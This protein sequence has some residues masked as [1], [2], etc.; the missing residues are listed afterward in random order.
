MTTINEEKT[1]EC[2]VVMYIPFEIW[3]DLYT[4]VK[5]SS[6]KTVDLKNL[7]EWLE[8]CVQNYDSSP[9]NFYSNRKK[10]ISNKTGNIISLT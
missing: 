2:T 4:V 10:V 6:C 8:E 7:K 5:E 9:V 3:D 1:V